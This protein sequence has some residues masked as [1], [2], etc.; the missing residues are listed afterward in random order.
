MNYEYSVDFADFA[1]VARCGE[2][3]YDWTE[4]V[5]WRHKTTGVLLWG[6]TSGCSCNGYEENVMPEDMVMVDSR[7]DAIDLAKG[8]G[9]TDSEITD[10]AAQLMPL[11]GDCAPATGDSPA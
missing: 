7:Q 11:P 10:F 5:L 1:E 2:Y 3:D 6:T 4:G 8:D 9:F